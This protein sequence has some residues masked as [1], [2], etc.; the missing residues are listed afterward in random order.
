MKKRTPNKGTFLMN[1]L[2]LLQCVDGGWGWGETGAL[3]LMC[4]PDADYVQ[5]HMPGGWKYT[6]LGPT[7]KN[8]YL[9]HLSKLTEQD[10][11]S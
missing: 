6:D 8:F 11:A 5:H 2:Y 7:Y 4:A 9:K 1:R 3:A 10:L